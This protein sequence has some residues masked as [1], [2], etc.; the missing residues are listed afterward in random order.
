VQ[1]RRKTLETKSKAVLYARLRAI[2]LGLSNRKLGGRNG[3]PAMA[4]EARI[5]TSGGIL[6]A[7]FRARFA[8]L[9]PS[10]GLPLGGLLLLSCP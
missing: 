1:N 4:K 6:S 7:R 10:L 8:S 9:R 5:G 3:E 2:R